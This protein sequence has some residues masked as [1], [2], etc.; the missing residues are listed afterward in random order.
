[1]EKIKR[2]LLSLYQF[3]FF[4]FEVMRGNCRFS[5]RLV[6][7]DWPHSK[8]RAKYLILGT[9]TN[10][11]ED[12]ILTEAWGRIY[13]LKSCPQ[14]EFFRK[15]KDCEQL[16]TDYYYMTTK[17]NLDSITFEGWLADRTQLWEQFRE[18]SKDFTPIAIRQFNNKFIIQD[19]AHR[20]SI[21]SLLGQESFEL[22]IGLWKFGNN[23]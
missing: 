17:E 10:V 23:L 5:P 13:P 4:V 14:R 3:G 19:G 16:D 2:L 11:G 18:D 15:L 12:H 7:G 21:C 6:I 9:I 20:I 1:M 8:S 22:G